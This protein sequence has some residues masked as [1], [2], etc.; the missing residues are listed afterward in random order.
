MTFITNSSDSSFTQDVAAGSCATSPDVPLFKEHH[1]LAGWQDSYGEPWDFST[2]IIEQDCYLYAVWLPLSYSITYVG[3]ECYEN[4][5][6]YVYGTE[7]TVYDGK[8][9]YYDFNGWFYDQEFTQPFTGIN[10]STYGDITLYASLSYQ[11]FK[12]ETNRLGYYT[13]KELLDKNAESINIPEEYKGK[14]IHEIGE[15]AFMG[16]NNLKS[17]TMHDNLSVIGSHAFNGCTS[18][19]TVNLGSAISQIGQ[20]AF[21]SCTSLKSIQ[22][23]STITRVEDYTFWQCTSLESI[24]IGGSI[25]YIG[26]S[27]F[28]DCRNLK[29]V[30]LGSMVS[31]IGSFAFSGCTGLEEINLDSGLVTIGQASFLGC[32]KL[33]S[34]R[35]CASVTQIGA[36]AF[37]NCTSLTIKCEAQSKPSGW[38][39][40]WNGTCEVIWNQ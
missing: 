39:D 29:S 37:R 33:E 27:A 15:K 1:Y 13:I 36:G 40:S 32:S 34:V 35:I 6:S 23:P 8:K 30:T 25:G 2:G 22:L 18:L 11:P 9:D 7:A 3:A 20:S 17:I 38:S 16:C 14:R 12:L 28:S 24:S 26:Q 31:Q 10:N 19:T 21:Y 4:P 5:T